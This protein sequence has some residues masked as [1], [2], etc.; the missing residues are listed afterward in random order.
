MKILKHQQSDK[1]HD[2]DS[3][4]N[5]DILAD[6][7]FGSVDKPSQSFVATTPVAFGVTTSTAPPTVT[8]SASCR[9]KIPQSPQKVYEIP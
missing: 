4:D 9:V 1:T 8:T 3:D 5:D 6:L 2:Y 7:M